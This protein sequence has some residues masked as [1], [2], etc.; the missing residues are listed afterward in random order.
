MLLEQMQKAKKKW[1][2][3]VAP[4][5]FNQMPMGETHVFDAREALGKSMSVNM[6]SLTK[7]PKKQGI[8]AKFLISGQH[9]NKLTTDFL[10]LRIM[11]PVIKR[12]VR[13]GKD[14]IE[15]SFLVNTVDGKK[16]RIKPIVIT[17]SKVK[18]SV[19]TAIRKAT[20]MH[21]ARVASK[22]AYDQLVEELINF[23]LQRGM[24]DLLNK[25]YPVSITE[26]RWFELV[27]KKDDVKKVADV[28]EV[29][30]AEDEKPAEKEE[31]KPTE[32]EPVEKKEEAKPV[33]EE[34]PVEAPKVEA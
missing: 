15:D 9:E 23:K 29:K 19:L 21:I 20:K 8:S 14:K 18:G 7:N 11:P 25:I 2:E 32:A 17:R 5:V 1:V 28:K 22:I 33:E 13:R 27:L 26:I 24:H 31:V 16:V 6:M 30:P 4:K 34:K 12:M 10:G 3:I